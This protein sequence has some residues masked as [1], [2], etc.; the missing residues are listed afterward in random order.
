MYSSGDAANP[1]SY[2]LTTNDANV[3]AGQQLLVTA[4]SLQA[5][6]TLNFNGSAETN[7]RFLIFGGRGADTI[8]GGAGNDRIIAGAGADVLTGGAGNDVFQFNAKTDSTPSARDTITDF[9]TGDRI[10][11]WFLDANDN[12]AGSQHFAFI[13]SAAF[14][15]AGQL[16]AVQQSPG[17]WLVEGD[18]N[19]DGVADFSLAVTVT[20]GH[21]LAA[22][23]F[24]L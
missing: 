11:L 19:G 1:N 8:V 16:R 12:L 22:G 4:M 6:E 15:A 24:L 21:A 23:D 5:N 3:A 14:S 9:V 10:D 7:G 20:D 13:G 17:N 2:K 18:T